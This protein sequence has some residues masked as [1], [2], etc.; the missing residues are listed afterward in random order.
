MGKKIIAIV[1]VVILVIGLVVGLLLVR[2]QQDLQKRATPATSVSVMPATITLPVGQNTKLTV[3]ADTNVNLLASVVLEVTYDPQKISL[4]SI[5]NGGFLPNDLE[6]AVINNTTG[7]TTVTLGANPATPPQ[8]KGTLVTLEFKG[9]AA[10]VSTIGF[11]SKTRGRGFTGSASRDNVDQADIIALKNPA[12][13]TITGG[14][15]TSPTPSPTASPVVGSTPTPSPSPSPTPA[16]GGTGTIASPTPTTSSSTGTKPTVSLPANKVVKA[17]AI[18]TGTAKPNSTI[19]IT[20]Q[21]DPITTTVTSDAVGK[22]SY[23]L[24]STLG[25][26]SHTITVT[27][28]NGTVTSNFTISSSTGTATVS[29]Q[30]VPAAGFDYPTIFG[31]G[32]GA[33]LLIFG[34]LLAL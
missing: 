30:N 13:I 15:I 10:G 31:L 21:S 19:T 5:T 9:M 4:V 26:G 25:A 17:G 14:T 32:G 6:K 12:S 16:A 22:W 33:L 28:S 8:G 34:L 3:E 29:A 18:I 23:T 1:V 7:S 11:G 20:V 27:D 24:P 2:Q